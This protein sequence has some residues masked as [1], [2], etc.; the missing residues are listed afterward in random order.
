MLPTG[1]IIV[2][3]SF[4]GL[5]GVDGL[6][7]YLSLFPNMPH[8]YAPRNWLRAGSGSLNGIALSMI[9]FPVF[10]YTLWRRTDP[11]TPLKN[12]WELL[13]V[14]AVDAGAVALVQSEPAWLL[15]PIALLTVGCVVW[16]LTMV[17]T[18]ILAI[19]FRYDSQAE[20]WRDAALPILGG[21]AVALVELTTMGTIRYL[22]TGTLGWPLAV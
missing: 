11:G 4:I 3:V 21:L 7:S 18:M 22:I 12:G 6:N 16:M 15:Y 14:L 9:V 10:N 17:N 19:M 13:P 5:M 8:L 1:I 20:S 2:M